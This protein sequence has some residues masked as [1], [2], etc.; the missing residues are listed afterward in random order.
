MQDTAEIQC[1]YCGETSCLAVDTTHGS[2]R[3]VTDCEVCCR[4]ME[5]HIECADG[6][7]LSL[8]VQAG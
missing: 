8:D 2:Q 6:E 7:I 3:L 5:V 4:P 1:P